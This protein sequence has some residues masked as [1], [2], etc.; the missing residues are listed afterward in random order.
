MAKVK[1]FE[2]TSFEAFYQIFIDEKYGKVVSVNKKKIEVL[3]RNI[4]RRLASRNKQSYK[5]TRVAD[6]EK[7]LSLE[8]GIDLRLEY[9][10]P[11]SLLETAL[12]ELKQIFHARGIPLRS[13]KAVPCRLSLCPADCGEQYRI[14]V[15][16]SEI[17][18]KGGSLEGLRRGIYELIDMLEESEGIFLPLKTAKRKFFIKNRISRS[19]CSPTHRPPHDVDELMNDVDYY[20]EKYLQTL[21]REGINALWLT[22]VLSEISY[23]SIQVPDANMEK[24]LAKLE[25]I[26]CRCRRYGIRIFIFFIEPAGFVGHSDLAE[27]HPELVGVDWGYGMHCFCPSSETAQ[28]HLYEQMFHLFERIPQLGGVINIPYGEMLCSC[29]FGGNNELESVAPF[30]CPRCRDLPPWRVLNNSLEPMLRGMRAVNPDA[31]YICWFYVPSSNQTIHPWFYECAKHLPEGVVM[32]CN[33]ESGIAVMQQGK[34][35]HGGDYWQGQPSCSDRFRKMAEVVRHAGGRMGAKMQI[36]NSHE[37]ATVPV[38]PIPATLYRKYRILRDLQVDTV[39]YSWYFGSFPG[40]MNRAA[41]QLSRCAVPGKISSFLTTLASHDYG[42]FASEA[43][44]AWQIFSRAFACYPVN[45]GLQYNGPINAGAT[46][47]LYPLSVCRDLTEAWQPFAQSGDCIGQC[48]KDYPIE[49][50]QPQMR[51]LSRLWDEG[52]RILRPLL[53]HFPSHSEAA[54]QIRF[55]EAI[56]HLLRT[57]WRIIRFYQLRCDLYAGKTR[58]LAEMEQIVRE[59][60]LVAEQL[61][62]LCRQ[63]FFIGYHSEAEI[64]KFDASQILKRKRQLEGLFQ[65]EFPLIRKRLHN[66]EP[67]PL[68][69]NLQTQRIKINSNIRRSTFSLQI[70]RQNDLLRF[71]FNCPFQGSMPDAITE[72]FVIQ[73]CDPLFVRYPVCFSCNP[74]K[75]KTHLAGS[76]YSLWRGEDAWGGSFF[77]GKDAVAPFP[78]AIQVIRQRLIHGKVVMESI[79]ESRCSGMRNCFSF[80]A[81]SM[82]LLEWE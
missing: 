27:K 39:M 5:S 50:A 11:E 80:K 59:E 65:K 57:A 25:S 81:A 18:L 23:S 53:E 33:F 12:Q 60:I 19:F 7:E 29:F 51:K 45:A 21:A 38:I 61:A 55:A 41:L 31:E 24:R 22:V 26:V 54:V 82:G 16:P 36:S 56:G 13:K 37:L 28:K 46:W 32:L 9:S 6:P 43:M 74:Q 64:H 49:E 14:A 44:K 1:T 75:A 42:M 76:H 67:L 71:D 48:L 8:N 40:L 20:P 35:R 10:D 47:F 4:C 70:S 68:S 79:W 66:G 72:Q 30:P 62:K 77:I 3:H 52:L 17:F 73:L 63:D 34:I 69:K 78:V 15:T 2:I 58:V